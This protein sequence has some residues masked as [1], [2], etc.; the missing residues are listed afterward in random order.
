MVAFL[1]PSLYILNAILLN[2]SGA[3]SVHA[4]LLLLGLESLLLASFLSMSSK[5]VRPEDQGN[6]F[7][8]SLD[9]IYDYCCG[10]VNKQLC[11]C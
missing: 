5:I 11:T 4:A 3:F 1:R 8:H 10:Q 6:L 9:F 2:E 7:S